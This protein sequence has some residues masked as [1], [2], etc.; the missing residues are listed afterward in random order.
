MDLS[1][2]L[3][4]MSICNA[5]VDDKKKFPTA[6]REVRIEKTIKYYPVIA[7]IPGNVFPSKYSNI[8][9]PP[10]LT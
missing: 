1:K 8:A 9:P 10:V 3:N 7:A 2:T 5:L 4:S 6:K